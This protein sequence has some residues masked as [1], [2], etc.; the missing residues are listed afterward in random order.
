MNEFSHNIPSAY[1]KFSWPKFLAGTWA[2]R[3]LF[4]NGIVFLIT[5]YMSHSIFSSDQRVLWILGAQDPVSLAQGEYWRYL[6]PMFLHGGLIHFFFNSMAIFYVGRDLEPILGGKWFFIIYFLSGLGG[7]IASAVF[8]VAQSVGASGAIF[9]LI[10][11]G[12]YLERAISTYIYQQTGDKP[13][14]GPYMLMLLIN[15]PISFLPM[16]DSN[17]HIG[18][19]VTGFIATFAIMR[20]KE[21]RMFMPNVPF[22]LA[23]MGGLC[24]VLVY[25]GLRGLDAQYITERL[26]F[27]GNEA[28]QVEEK[29]FHY[30][31]ALLLDP[32]HGDLLFRRGSLLINMGEMNT[33]L[34]DLVK[35]NKDPHIGE[36]IS[37]F[38]L[39][40]ESKNRTEEAEILKKYFSSGTNI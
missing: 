38:I 16:I 31:R 19:L 4:V 9:G 25:G 34:A 11:S 6:T 15:L 8:S 5:A 14:R 18:G 40:L 35:A 32:E 23:V 30:S 2:G 22:A 26:I 29:V 12:L 37:S 13:R 7:S 28:T 1:P 36:K 21:N 33:G 17:A 3:I 10:G 39:E 27:K 24:A 20:V